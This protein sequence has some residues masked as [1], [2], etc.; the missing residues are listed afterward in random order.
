MIETIVAAADLVNAVPS[1]W[2]AIKIPLSVTLLAAGAGSAI[3]SL[4]RGFGTAAGKL[5][6]AMALGALMLG[7]VGLTNSLKA[8]IDRHSGGVTIGQYGR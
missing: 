5:I 8:T 4:H 6:G 7:G 3:F 1:L 2:E